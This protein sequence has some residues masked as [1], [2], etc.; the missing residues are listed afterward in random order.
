MTPTEDLIRLFDF[1]DEPLCVQHCPSFTQLRIFRLRFTNVV[2]QSLGFFVHVLERVN[3][4]LFFRAAYPNRI[5]LR[6]EP[7]VVG[8]PD[9]RALPKLS[10]ELAPPLQFPYA[11]PLF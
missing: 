5:L 4:P 11:I 2:F 9:K 6:G 7:K 10:L 3:V 1:V 8:V